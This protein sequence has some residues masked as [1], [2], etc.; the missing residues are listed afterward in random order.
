MV[1]GE[2]VENGGQWWGMVGMVEMVGN[3][4]GGNGELVDAGDGEWWMVRWVDV[5]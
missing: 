3:G 2:V 4:D 5:K 1:H